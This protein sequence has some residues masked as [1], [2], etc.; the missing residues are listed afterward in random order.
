MFLCPLIF[1]SFCFQ[2]FTQIGGSS[3]PIGVASIIG[4][5]D[6]VP[7]LYSFDPSATLYVSV[8]F[9]FLFSPYIPVSRA[10]GVSRLEKKS[11]KPAQTLKAYPSTR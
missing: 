4:G 7:Q 8:A 2:Q 5:F 1:F 9:F 10:I 11:P 3:R 6:D